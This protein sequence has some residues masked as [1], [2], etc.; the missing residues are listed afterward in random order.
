MSPS[1]VRAVRDRLGLSE[2]EFGRALHLEG[3]RKKVRELENG[4]RVASPQM[5]ALMQALV[6]IHDLEQR[7]EN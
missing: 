6:R 2:V 3:P 4:A 7:K 5:I 1:E